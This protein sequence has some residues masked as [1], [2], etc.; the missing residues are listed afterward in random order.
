MLPQ[1]TDRGIVAFFK[2]YRKDVVTMLIRQMDFVVHYVAGLNAS[3]KK[4]KTSSLTQIQCNW[5]VT[6]LMGIIVAGSFSWAG[7]AR[8]SLGVS[9]ESQLRW[10]FRYAKI[11]WDLLLQASVAHLISHYGITMGVLV[12]DDSDKM[13]SRNTSKI[14][15]V[16]KVKDKKTGGWFMGQE[17]VFLI[18]VTNTV[19][20]V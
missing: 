4:L 1:K 6:I 19:T 18:L 15:G 12:L 9:N 11:A 7:F 17:F 5:L 13:R 2:L 20:I 16:H 14:A 8:R 3:L 10:M